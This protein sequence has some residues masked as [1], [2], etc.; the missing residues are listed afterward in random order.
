MKRRN[1]GPKDESI[2]Y[3][4]LS[5]SASVSRRSPRPLARLLVAVVLACG[6]LL[7]ACGSDDGATSSA[8][9]P[10]DESSSTVVAGASGDGESQLPSC[11]EV[12]ASGAV[13]DAVSP[14]TLI[15]V[16]TTSYERES[17]IRCDWE[18]A[19]GSDILSLRVA[20]TD[21]AQGQAFEQFDDSYVQI[22]DGL[23]SHAYQ[24]L[25]TERS[26]LVFQVMTDA[27]VVR[28]QANGPTVGAPE[29]LPVIREQVLS[30]AGV[31]DNGNGPAPNLLD[32]GT[33]QAK[34][35]ELAPVSVSKE[36]N[37]SNAL[38]EYESADHPFSVSISRTA[39]G[40]KT[41][42][43][44]DVEGADDRQERPDLAP[45]AIV[46]SSSLDC[47]VVAGRARVAVV[48]LEDGDVTQMC[49]MAEELFRA[50]FPKG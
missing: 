32:C 48:N 4:A 13:A 11:E 44:V 20:R 1:L 17:S 36:N 45:G 5:R 25:D 43:E 30:I 34:V 49:S 22:I 42:A 40:L 46:A 2:G 50:A 15:A 10:T 3:S 41:D 29:F 12:R 31:P 18:V 39:T 8:A 14:E 37:D 23:G 35:Q 21:D 9:D 26:A 27:I 6:W 33:L 16:D 7:G 19:D 24:W 38:C 28:L 47:R